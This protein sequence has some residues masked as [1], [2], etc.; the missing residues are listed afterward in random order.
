V[1]FAVVAAFP[2]LFSSFHLNDRATA[3]LLEALKTPLAASIEVPAP[4][5]RREAY[6]KHWDYLKK[7]GT[8]S[9]EGA[10]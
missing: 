8:L 2:L 5:A 1:F 10:T 4:Q 7:H 9:P 6:Y 3:P